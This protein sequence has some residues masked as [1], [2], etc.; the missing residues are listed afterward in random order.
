MGCCISSPTGIDFI[1]NDMQRDDAEV[2]EK[3]GKVSTSEHNYLDS[4][5]S[6][7]LFERNFEN[8]S[9]EDL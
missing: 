9:L 5:T 2:V 6:I 3:A 1:I 8:D 4:S 7:I